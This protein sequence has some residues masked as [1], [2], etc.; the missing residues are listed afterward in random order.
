MKRLAKCSVTALLFCLWF[1]SNNLNAQNAAA[2]NNGLNEKEKST[3][4]ISSLTAKGD[5]IKLKAALAEGLE[6]K[7]TVNEIKEILV[8][9][10][11]YCG[12]PRSLNAIN[13]FKTLLEER[14]AKGIKDIEGQKIV[15]ENNT[16]NKY[17]QGRKTLEK[18]S[19]IPQPK[20]AP[21]Y[22]E[23][24]PRIDL[25]LKEH[26]FAD[27][28]S[29]TVLNYKQREF[30]TIAAL[31]SMEGVEAQLN[32]H[33]KVGKNTGITDSQLAELTGLIEIHINRVQ[34]NTVRKA[35]DQPLLPLIDPQMMIRISEIEIVP[36]YL[37]E[38]NKIL[39]EEAAASIKIEPGVIAIFPMSH[40]TNPTQIRIVEIYKDSAAYQSHLKTP[41]FFH[42]KSSTLKMVRSLR[43][44]DM[45][46]M[47]LEMMLNIFKKIK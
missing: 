5:L 8:Q 32:S 35:T 39:K 11:A 43:L 14:K 26:L 10:Y 4:I 38:Y 36:E 18:L 37:E 28:F 30:V 33:I 47:D 44:I 2:S 25:F 45:K 42:Y 41:H 46:P 6:A 31:T 17:E 1:I 20:P 24:A 34:A 16:N 15:I 12:F 3:I 13:T 19:G 21:G 29:S 27:V 40:Q 9:L 22:G 23:F 7:L